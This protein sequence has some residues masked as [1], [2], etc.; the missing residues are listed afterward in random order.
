MRILACSIFL[1]ACAPLTAAAP[2]SL[3]EQ[4]EDPP[5]D[6][7]RVEAVAAA[8]TPTESAREE[9]L[10]PGPR[11]LVLGRRDEIVSGDRDLPL[12]AL[13]FDAGAAAGSANQLLDV[14]QQQEV[15]STFFVT[16]A[17][18][19]RYPNLVARIAAEGHELA[20]HSY[21][22]P[23]FRNLTESQM[24]TEIR[25]A[26]AAIEAASGVS[27]VSLWRPPFGSRDDRI[28]R[29]VDDEGY[30]AIYWTLDSGDWLD[31]A[32]EQ[33]VRT[34]VLGK[35]GPGAIVV[36]HISPEATARAMPAIIDGLR[37]QGYRLVTV[38]QIMG[39]A[40]VCP[41]P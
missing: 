20:N 29:V 32:T 13:T 16:G 11:R 36:D 5:A 19:D 15:R 34:T 25:R 27:P 1:C 23:D 4:S 21:S 37:A 40:P 39:E 3:S 24:R 38:S 30:R 22:H 2:P 6:Q 10:S 28:L 33:R 26:A 9:C 8:A 7:T 31:D 14:L 41:A 35:T 17:F 12:V 18:A